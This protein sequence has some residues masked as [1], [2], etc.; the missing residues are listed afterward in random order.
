MAIQNLILLYGD[1]AFDSRV[2]RISSFIASQLGDTQLLSLKRFSERN[3][4]FNK[5]NSLNHIE[6]KLISEKLPKNGKWGYLKY[7]EGFLRFFSY[8]IRAKLIYCNDLSTLPIAYFAKIFNTKIKI[9]YDSHEVA[10]YQGTPSKRK[11]RLKSLF[12]RILIRKADYVFTVSTRISKWYRRVYRLQHV[13]TIF[14]SPSFYPVA[15]CKNFINEDSKIEFVWHGIFSPHRGIKETI[16]VF[17]DTEVATKANVTFIGWGALKNDIKS[18]SNLFPNIKILDPVSQNELI[19][20]LQNFDCGLF[21]YE[22]I[23]KNYDWA[24]PNKLFEFT[25]AGI[26]VV[27]YPLSE[28]NYTITKYNIGYVANDFS[29]CSLKR[30]V[31]DFIDSYEKNYE[32]FSQ[33]TAK[34]INSH[35]WEKQKIKISNALSQLKNIN[36]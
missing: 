34:F 14:N 32:I 20:A 31:L 3:Y 33:N 1:I 6:I 11:I 23:S 4:E 18:F 35:S 24:M 5:P 17:Q 25:T 2:K 28:A 13:E 12:E 8:S 16:R 30:S 29:S 15:R 19:N 27:S 10:P 22:P 36:E 7:A 21:T 26:P 9:I